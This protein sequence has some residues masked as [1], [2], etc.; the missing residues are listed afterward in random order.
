MSKL[1]A[2]APAV[3]NELRA[4]CQGMADAIEAR[5]WG[6]FFAKLIEFF[7]VVLPFV[8]PLFVAPVDPPTPPAV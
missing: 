1:S 3:H 5:D 8:L 4:Q 2:A 7:K 6:A